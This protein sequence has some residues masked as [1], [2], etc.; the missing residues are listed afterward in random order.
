MIAINNAYMIVQIAISERGTRTMAKRGTALTEQQINLIIDLFKQ[1][2]KNG[3]IA[4]CVGVAEGTVSRR[5]G[6][7]LGTRKTQVSLCSC[8]KCVEDCLNCK[9][10][11][12]DYNGPVRPFEK[13]T[14][15]VNSWT[16]DMYIQVLK[17]A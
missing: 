14:Q 17:K 5:I 11:D 15:P 13:T 10:I 4:K 1:G 8:S 12:C 7:I 2:V 3:E 9:K 6:E 16:I